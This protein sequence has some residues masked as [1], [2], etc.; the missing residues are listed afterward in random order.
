[1]LIQRIKGELYNVVSKEKWRTD[2]TFTP[3]YTNDTL[4][5][6]SDLDSSDSSVSNSISID[7]EGSFLDLGN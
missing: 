1:M 3:D 7:S 5:D 4:Y 2:F 6:S